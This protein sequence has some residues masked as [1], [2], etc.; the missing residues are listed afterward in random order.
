MAQGKR[1]KRTKSA[2]QIAVDG[3]PQGIAYEEGFRIL[4]TPLGFGG[5]KNADLQFVS[6]V[7]ER[8]PRRCKSMLTTPFV[9]EAVGA[10]KRGVDT[11]SLSYD[12]RI[13]LGK[14]DIRLFPAGLG[15]GSAQ[16]EVAYKGCKIVFSGGVRLT[17]Q[18]GFSPA[19]FS[20]CDLLL[21][22]AAPAQARPPSPER[23]S[24]K[25]KRWVKK[26]IL[27]GKVPI[28]CF[29]SRGAVLDAAWSLRHMDNR[30][31][32]YRP[33]Y[34][35]LRRVE[36]VGF[37]L[38]RLRRLGQRLPSHGIVF[39]FSHLW[40]GPK[41][42]EKD[43]RVAYVGPG[44]VVPTWASEAFRLGESE[45]RSGLV[46]Y[47]SKMQPSQVALGPRC[48]EATSKRLCEEGFQVYR[49]HESKQMLLSFFENDFVC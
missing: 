6:H 31:C 36:R 18:N 49:I 19:E 48:D 42:D 15:P 32:A 28:L 35:M 43:I 21:L 16:L 25:L 8:L 24:E 37:S 23:V 1:S 46:S 14:L 22:D 3:L 45:S 33:I 5:A 38:T 41:I 2:Y 9:A 30:V 13:R 12:R 10:E 39:H 47:V 17:A 4:G 7:D 40:P 20:K 44:K 11:L 29:G 27:D 26:N 34:D